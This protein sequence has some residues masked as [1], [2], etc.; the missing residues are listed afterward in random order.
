MQFS[1][2]E[3]CETDKHHIRCWSDSKK[4]QIKLVETALLEVLAY[5]PLNLSLKHL[6]AEGKSSVQLWLAIVLFSHQVMVG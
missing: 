2:P 1:K 6:V 3:T 5:W 4:S